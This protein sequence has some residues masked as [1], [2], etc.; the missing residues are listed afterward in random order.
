MLFLALVS[1][2]STRKRFAWGLGPSCCLDSD[3]P[4]I[5]NH[6]STMGSI[7]KVK[8]K[9]KKDPGPLIP[10]PLYLVPT[11]QNHHTMK[12]NYLASITTALDAVASMEQYL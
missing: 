6:D 1:F 3:K 7:G 11:L 9:I 12:A 10:D 2:F 8:I 4:S 5:A